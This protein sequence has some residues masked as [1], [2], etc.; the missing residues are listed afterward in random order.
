MLTFLREIRKS[1]LVSGSTRKYLLYAIGEIA[2]VVI[3]I[4]IALQIN[5]WNEARKNADW[6]RYYVSR[7]AEDIRNDVSEIN[8]TIRASYRRAVIGNS[9]LTDLGEDYL[10]DGVEVFQPMVVNFL[11]EAKV[12]YPDTDTLK[13]L[14]LNIRMRRITDFRSIT[15]RRFTYDELMSSGRLEMIKSNKLRESISTYYWKVNDFIHSENLPKVLDS[16][17]EFL[18]QENIPVADGR[19][20]TSIEDVV[21]DIDGYKTVLKNLLYEHLR[22]RALYLFLKQRSDSLLEEVNA[23]IESL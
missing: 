21:S 13:Y 3:G 1:F 8:A 4:L 18:N 23:Y 17:I 15:I 16:Y 12:L 10:H 14:N 7:L 19:A 5:N 9:I 20:Y 22:T 2:L 6:E 11:K